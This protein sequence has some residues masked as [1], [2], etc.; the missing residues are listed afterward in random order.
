M[1]I[2]HSTLTET[3]RPNPQDQVS[4]RIL[5]STDLHMNL[6][7]YD[8]YRDQADPGVGLSRTA[9]LIAKARTEAARF[10]AATLLLDNGDSLQGAPL[11]EQPSASA[12]HPLMR[13]FQ[14]L[15]YDAIGV[16]NHDF[17]FGIETLESILRDAPCP[18]ICSNMQAVLPDIQLPFVTSAILERRI[19]AHPN[20]P[21]VRIGLLSVLPEQ[22]MRW[23]A[24]QLKGRVQV[25]NMVQ[26]ARTTSAALRAEGCDVV[27]ALAH[28]G[29]GHVADPDDSENALQRLALID[30]IDALIGGHTHL[31][32]PD[33]AIPF[34]KPVVMPGSF[35]S[36]L[37]VIDLRLKH[38]HDGWALDGWDCGLHPI[39]QRNDTGELV[40][41]VIEDA[42]LVSVLADDHAATIKRINEPVGY[43]AHSLHSF[44]TFFAPDRALALVACAQAAALRALAVSDLPVISAVSPCKFGARTGPDYFTNVAAGPLYRRH[45]ADLHVFPNLL[46]A[47]TLSGAM[48]IE[49]LEMSAGLFNQV[50]PG[51]CGTALV[52]PDRAGHNFDVLHGLDYQID[53]SVPA[54]FHASGK[55][56]DRH[57]HRIR[58]PRWN[59]QPIDPDQQF[60]VA[61]N[62]HRVV[63]GGNFSMVLQAK[64]LPLPRQAIGDIIYDYLNG[65]LPADPLAMA[66]PPWC[67]A[68]LPGTQALVYTGPAARPYLDELSHLDL[69]LPQ[70]TEDGFLQLR[71]PL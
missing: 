14:L 64:Q 6:L 49:W 39:S 9:T 42:A 44:F 19:P 65:T 61:V 21:P 16:G 54:R 41:K 13:A 63:G 5:A 2:E 32:L 66:P 56:A 35:G 4:L 24:H 15:N 36:H 29:V 45:V 59:G 30:D 17:N 7:G 57:A 60:V 20:A 68:S 62:S 70:L 47:V 23:D 1:R 31:H 22:T 58:D 51:S 27:I 25:V 50:T 33:P 37:G 8:Y 40:P 38:D 55:L 48:V 12:I 18:V 71:I 53:L 52:N 46:N 67:L 28:T 34:S 43:S 26:A 3:K 69:P 10:G 11:G